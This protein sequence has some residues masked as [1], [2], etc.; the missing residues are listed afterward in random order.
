MLCSIGHGEIPNLN[1][2]FAPSCTYAEIPQYNYINPFSQII[3]NPF[4]H[5][6]KQI[7]VP[8]KGQIKI[9]E[10]E[11]DATNNTQEKNYKKIFDVS[12]CQ[13]SHD[14][15]SE[16]V[17][18]ETH[19]QSIDNSANNNI[20][21]ICE[22]DIIKFN[23]DKKLKKIHSI[24]HLKRKVCTK[25]QNQIKSDINKLIIDFNKSSSTIKIPFLYPCSKQ[26]RE[27]VKLDTLKTIKNLTMAKYINEDIQSAGRSLNIKNTK[28]VDLIVDIAEKNKDNIYIKKLYD[29]IF[30]TIVVDY[31]NDFLGS[32]SF[33]TCLEKDLNKYIDK[34]NSFKY[35]NEKIQIYKKI[36]KE[37]YEGIAKYLFYNN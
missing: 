30:N 34:L 37:K 32:N 8:K 3:I 6:N 21:F 22:K 18:H 7:I 35:P 1:F 26:F 12:N 24:Y 9:I 17:S 27:D 20:N 19:E 33:K 23:G 14:T 10:G 28:I 25:L 11:N 36:F 13:T 16:S 15:S 5:S 31:Y 2:S 4:I 29:F